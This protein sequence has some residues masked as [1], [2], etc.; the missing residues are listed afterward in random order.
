KFA[1]IFCLAALLGIL[2]IS[3]GAAQVISGDL[4]GSVLDKTGAGVPGAT[5]EATNADTGVKTETR[6]SETGAYRFSNLPVGN[7]NVSA[8]AP[9]FAN[10]V[11]NGFRVE[12]NKI[13]TLQIT[14]EVKGAITSVEVSGAPASLD[15]TTAQVQSTFE[16]KETADSAIAS[17]GGNGS[18]V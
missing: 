9:N 14:L 13:S 10:T 16:S 4:V 17:T 15:T 3:N 6:S 18:G 12:L 8:S 7:Y 11:I 2:S 5:I 1:F